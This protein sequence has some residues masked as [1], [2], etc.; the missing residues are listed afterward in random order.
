MLYEGENTVIENHQDCA[1]IDHFSKIA[2]A[3]RLAIGPCILHLLVCVFCFPIAFLSQDFDRGM[4]CFWAIVF[5]GFVLLC[6]MI[7]L[8]IQAYP[9]WLG[10]I[11]LLLIS[12]AFTLVAPLL[13]VVS[14]CM[15]MS[16]RRALANEG[17]AMS[18]LTV[19]VTEIEHARTLVRN[20]R[21]DQ[22]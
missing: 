16:V 8:S 19:R 3:H 13:L 20:Y 17:F 7:Y 6:F 14:G 1:R 18:G 10:W 12:A 21:G 15:L 2:T 22:R 11:L 4:A 5:S 9:N